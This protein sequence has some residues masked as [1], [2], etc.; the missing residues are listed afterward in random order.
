MQP[1][2]MGKFLGAG[3]TPGRPKI[4]KDRALGIYFAERLGLAGEVFECE[5]N[6]LLGLRPER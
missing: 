1:L 6:G 2:E 3:D 5:I 4:K